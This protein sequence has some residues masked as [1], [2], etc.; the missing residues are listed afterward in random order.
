MSADDLAQALRS[1]EEARREADRVW[2]SQ[3][4]APRLR[5]CFGEREEDY[6]RLVERIARVAGTA[7]PALIEGEP[8]H[9][10]ALVALAIHQTG[11]RDRPFVVVHGGQG[12]RGPSGLRRSWDE[13]FGKAKGGSLLATHIDILPRADQAALLERLSPE[14]PRLLV[15]ATQDLGT[16]DHV[17]P[18]LHQRLSVL[19]LRLTQPGAPA[20]DTTQTA[21]SLEDAERRIIAAR[22]AAFAWQQQQ[23]ADS[24]GI[25]RKTLYR[26]IRRYGL[27]ESGGPGPPD[28]TH[29]R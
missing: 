10:L 28:I 16:A 18:E 15:T 9:G 1:L 21:E 8:G 29:V 26:K 7:I 20:K 14:G 17:L 6:Q 12:W 4:A 2:A 19:R 11:G 24:L 22:L 23:T 5:A 13:V 25:D 3:P 27:G